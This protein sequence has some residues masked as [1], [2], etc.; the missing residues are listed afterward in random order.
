MDTFASCLTI[1]MIFPKTLPSDFRG[2]RSTY[3]GER[4]T[5]PNK[6]ELV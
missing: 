6:V 4:K 2:L 5:V 3:F 1:V